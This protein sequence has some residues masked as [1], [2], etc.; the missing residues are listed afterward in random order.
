LAER[1]RLGALDLRLS[2]DELAAL[3][4]TIPPA[5]VAG[6]PRAYITLGSDLGISIAA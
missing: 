5:Q 1:D 3:E 2:A 4:A 6:D